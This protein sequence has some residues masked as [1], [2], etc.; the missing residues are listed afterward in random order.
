MAN[1]FIFLL[2]EAATKVWKHEKL[3]EICNNSNT[4][5]T[6]FIIIETLIVSCCYL[7]SHKL[8]LSCK[9]AELSYLSL[10]PNRMNILKSIRENFLL[11]R[12]NR[13][14]L[15]DPNHNRDHRAIALRQPAPERNGSHRRV[16]NSYAGWCLYWILAPGTPQL[17]V[18][19][20]VL[21]V[22]LHVS[23][24]SGTAGADDLS[25]LSAWFVSRAHYTQ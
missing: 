16:I 18:H 6:N 2:T 23:C 3:A 11:W 22:F 1:W 15:L 12:F 5:Q 21:I 20:D 8:A 14:K 24:W 13:Q 9:F 19:V 7:S 17:I 25:N 4:K 10:Q